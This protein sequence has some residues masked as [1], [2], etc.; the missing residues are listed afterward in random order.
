MFLLLFCCCQASQGQSNTVEVRKSVNLP[1]GL[2]EASGIEYVNGN[3]WTHNDGQDGPNLLKIDIATGEVNRKLKL[4]DASNK[5]W[6]DITSDEKYLYIGDIGNNNKSRKKLTI[7]KVEIATMEI[8]GS[9][10]YVQLI[11]FVYPGKKEGKTKNYN[12]EAI[13]VKDGL[14]YVIT[15]ENSGKAKIYSLNTVDRDQRGQL[16]SEIELSGAVTGATFDKNS[17]NLYIIGYNKITEQIYHPFL[18]IVDNFLSPSQSIKECTISESGQMEGIT[19]S[20]GNIII[21]SET[22]KY[23]KGK[24]LQIAI[25]KNT[26]E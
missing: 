17:N 3:F 22:T 26:S 18:G 14:L 19:V 6:E 21:V 9:Q 12:S 2:S 4:P 8:E 5:D 25:P 13:F 20:Q 1:I 23:K 7:Y 10:P 16:V 24:I 11:Q 15:K